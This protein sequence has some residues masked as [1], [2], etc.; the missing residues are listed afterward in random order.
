MIINIMQV[1]FQDKI[2]HTI[3]CVS[4]LNAPNDIGIGKYRSWLHV[5]QKHIK[6]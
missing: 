2:K 6:N 3:L 1:L 4:D 5:P